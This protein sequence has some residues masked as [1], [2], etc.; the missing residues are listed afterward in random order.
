ME[1]C[2]VEDLEYSALSGSGESCCRMTLQFVDPTSSVVGKSFKMTLPEA[3]GFPDF[4]VERTRYEAA[5]ARNWTCRDKCQVWWKNEG[6]E[7]GSWWDGRI[8]AVKPKSPEFPE[9]PWER[10]VVQ[11]KSE[12]TETHGHSPWELYDADTQWEQPRIDDE[13]R[14]RILR[15]FVKLEQSGNK[16][17]VI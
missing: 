6:E 9:S 17:K 8:Q 5:M 11:Y 14:E 7:D 15:A 12:P 2:K 4:L 13:I 16:P 1:F 3:T 10:Y